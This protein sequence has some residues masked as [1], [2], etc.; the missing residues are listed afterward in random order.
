[1]ILCDIVRFVRWCEVSKRKDLRVGVW[2]DSLPITFSV[3]ADPCM[4]VPGE[5]W[6]T[7]IR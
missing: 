5:K 4:T 7:G 2:V 1:M 3:K 6:P